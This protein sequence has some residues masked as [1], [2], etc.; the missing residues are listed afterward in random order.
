VIHGSTRWQITT[1]C[2]QHAPFAHRPFRPN[3]VSGGPVSRAFATAEPDQTE[4]EAKAKKQD[5]KALDEQEQ[6]VRAK[7]SQVKRPWHRHGV[8]DPPVEKNGSKAAP[9]TIGRYRHPLTCPS[10][11]HFRR[12]VEPPLTR[13]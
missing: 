1:R 4:S 13:L 5:Q 6:K 2:Q 8:D 7:E 10:A 11:A 9:V 12:V 3:R